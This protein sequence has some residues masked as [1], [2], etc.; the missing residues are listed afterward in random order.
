MIT[1]DPSA[2]AAIEG[3]AT[4]GS[5]M[6][7]NKPAFETVA[8][9]PDDTAVILYTSGTTGQPKGAELPLFHSFGQTV[10]MNAGL[11]CGEKLVLLPRFDPQETYATM[12]SDDVSVF[13][14]VPTMYWGLLDLPGAESEFNLAKIKNTNTLRICVSGGSSLPVEIIRQFETRFDVA[15]LEGYGLSETAPVSTFSN[16]EYERKPGSIGKPIWGVEIMI[17][18]KDDREVPPGEVGELVI[19]GPNVM[20]GYYNRREATERAFKNSWF[21][22]GDMARAD[23]DGFCY[24]VDRVKDMIIRGGYNVYPREIEEVLL[25][26]PAVSM[27]AVIGVPHTL[28]RYSGIPIG[29]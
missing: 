21:H 9:S 25:T 11:L 6:A 24:I 28:S 7:G 1:A 15:I 26:H 3:V 13:C 27:A 5:L 19:K 22:T 12:Q 10:Q 20:K 23:E 4:L 17:V 16:L 14:A 8:T 18:D 29:R 2:P